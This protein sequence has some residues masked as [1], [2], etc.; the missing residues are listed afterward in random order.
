MDQTAPGATIKAKND[1]V[2][3]ILFVRQRNPT[4]KLA[5]DIERI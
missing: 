5:T 2:Y 4:A 1:Q 3:L